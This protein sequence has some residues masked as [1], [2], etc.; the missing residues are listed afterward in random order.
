VPDVSSEV[1]NEEALA[2]LSGRRRADLLVVKSAWQW[3]FWPVLL[4]TIVA[5]VGTAL[6]PVPVWS[7]GPAILTGEGSA[8]L[9]AA[10]PQHGRPDF[11]DL[12]LS[13]ENAPPRAIALLEPSAE[14][15]SAQAAKALLGGDPGAA[16][17]DPVLLVRGRLARPCEVSC[18]PTA[19]G[20]LAARV[21]SSRLLTA[22]LSGA[23][24]RGAF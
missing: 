17:S 8:T 11:A 2:F 3:F 7:E 16:S 9:V 18:S 6:M 5:L 10:L 14:L 13:L 12:R 23:R 15:S 21:G 1:F 4:L 22:L 19:R 24:G 20:R